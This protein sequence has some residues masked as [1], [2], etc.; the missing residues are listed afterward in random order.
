MVRRR[1]G[2]GW[3]RRPSRQPQRRAMPVAHLAYFL[4]DRRGNVPNWEYRVVWH[5]LSETWEPGDRLW[6]DGWNHNMLQVDRWVNT[7]RR[8]PY[9]HWCI[10]QRLDVRPGLQYLR[11]IR[12][13]WGE[14]NS[15]LAIQDWARAEGYYFEGA[16]IAGPRL[17]RS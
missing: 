17:R 10:S 4:R 6:E 11:R 16:N 7:Q 2:H 5:D 12:E 3:F 9:L 13:L 1:R 8:L 15:R 14:A